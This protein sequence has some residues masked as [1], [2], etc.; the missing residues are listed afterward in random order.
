MAGA[1]IRVA[2]GS[3]ERMR[4][5]GRNTQLGLYLKRG[6]MNL[7]RS[8][9]FVV[10]GTQVS[11]VPQTFAEALS[12]HPRVAELE[13]KLNKDASA[14]LKARFP[15]QPF[16][17]TA[18]ID[19]VRR[20]TSG[21]AKGRKGERNPDEDLPFFDV[22]EPEDTMVDEW[23]D[24]SISLNQ[25]MLRTR[26]VLVEVSLPNT[27][28]DE[29]ILEVRESL[30]KILHLVPA[31]D[32]VQVTKRAWKT[33][34]TT[35][36]P[37]PDYS[38][39]V[40]AIAGVLAAAF[41]LISLLTRASINRLAKV[42]ASG[43]AAASQ[44]GGAQSAPPTVNVSFP[45]Q[46]MGSGGGG[47]RSLEGNFQVS[48]A[49]KMREQ[50]GLLVDRFVHEKN[51]PLLQDMIELDRF[52]REN[53]SAMGALLH[54]FPAEVRARILSYGSDQV[55]L[56]ASFKA[57]MLE[58]GC[59]RVLSSMARLSREDV[60]LGFEGLLIRVW[61]LEMDEKIRLFRMLD[62]TEGFYLLDRLPRGVAI[63]AARRVYP[64]SWGTVLT[65]NALLPPLSPDRIL[66]V[67]AMAETI[68][69]LTSSAMLEDYR[70][71]MELLEFLKNAEF[72]E[73]RDIYAALKPDSIIFKMRPSFSSLFLLS[74]EELTEIV[75]KFTPVQWAMALFG[76]P[77]D[78][79]VKIDSILSEK[80]RFVMDDELRRLD[81][82][83]P[84]KEQVAR[85]RDQIARTKA[86][87]LPSAPAALNPV[88][89]TLNRNLPPSPPGSKPG[90]RGGS[91]DGG[92]SNAA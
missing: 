28:S 12:K 63:P 70:R 60:E 56:E 76:T 67:T 36:P 22:Q 16:L 47:A 9:A 35:T 73:E 85:I 24:P 89:N 39:Y 2:G 48:D 10:L 58:P 49:S 44:S 69:P 20:E 68:R 71:D 25:L 82:A 3:K 37:T 51:F 80:Q 75:Q 4:Y 29:E 17:V 19:P 40:Y 74:R 41:L 53:L 50:V 8:A 34:A 30:T 33:A 27:I 15:D 31:R 83:A 64:G 14:Y 54:E 1:R 26:K 77:R 62:Q 38:K 87:A 46:E 65:G 5:Q 7:L 52:A 79:R 42:V 55:W 72:E 13:D 45:A 84:P 66:Q 91:E 11:G 6:V 59:L 32:D 78:E 21:N 81:Q 92:A 86:A 23:D 18:S 88:P 43:G 57:G 90:M 61:R